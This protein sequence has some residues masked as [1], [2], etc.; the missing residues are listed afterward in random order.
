MAK[1]INF[2][3]EGKEYYL[4]FDRMSVKRLES[5][6]FNFD[7]LDDKPVTMIPLFFRGAFLKNHPKEKPNVIDKIFDEISDKDKLIEALAEM[8]VETLQ[9][10]MDE[11]EKGVK[12]TVD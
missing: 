4:E 3:F 5:M 2:T 8:Y 10:L 11:P 6:G 1:K 7:L 12:W 9:S